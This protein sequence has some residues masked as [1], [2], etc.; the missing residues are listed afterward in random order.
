MRSE[1]L[2]SAVGAKRLRPGRRA[3]GRLVPDHRPT[4]QRGLSGRAS[5]SRKRRHGSSNGANAHPEPLDRLARTF[6]DR[7]EIGSAHQ[8]LQSNGGDKD[9]RKLSAESRPSG[10]HW[11]SKASHRNGDL[12]A[13]SIT[14]AP[15]TE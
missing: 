6:A 10:R 8:L 5:C 1:I 3:S 7:V 2:R 12:A 4:P 14:A 13:C 11:W 15:H 9:V